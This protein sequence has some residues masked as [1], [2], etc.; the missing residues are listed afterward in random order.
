[1]PP[2]T[3]LSEDGYNSSEDSDFIPGKIDTNLD[4]ISS[5]SDS[6]SE[7][8]PTK[9]RKHVSNSRSACVDSYDS[10]DEKIISISKQDKNPAEDA[11]YLNIS[12]DRG[13][14]VIKTRSQRLK[15]YLKSP[16]MTKWITLK[17]M[18]TETKLIRNK[19]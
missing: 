3:S 6:D 17:F 11:R 2:S 16:P 4:D 18:K 9:K 13:K 1:M 12:G 14:S 10:G 15:E 8:G 5:D 7:N 19:S